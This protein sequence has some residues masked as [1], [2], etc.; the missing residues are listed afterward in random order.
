MIRSRAAGNEPATA[1][2]AG[3]EGARDKLKRHRPVE[4]HAALGGVHGL[5]HAKT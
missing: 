5:S 4:A 1:R 3:T 2:R